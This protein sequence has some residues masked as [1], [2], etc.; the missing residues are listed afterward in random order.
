MCASPVSGTRDIRVLQHNLSVF[1]SASAVCA[2]AP[3]VVDVGPATSSAACCFRRR[4][5]R[6]FSQNTASAAAITLHAT[7]AQ[8]TGSQEPEAA[9]SQAAHGPARIEPTPFEVYWMP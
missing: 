8:K 9:I 7:A 5:T 6:G 2:V 3:Y 1:Y 4:D